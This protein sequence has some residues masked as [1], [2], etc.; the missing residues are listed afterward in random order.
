LEEGLYHYDAIDRL[1]EIKAASERGSDSTA[2]EDLGRYIKLGPLGTAL[3]PGDKPRVLLIDEIDKADIDLPNDLLHVF[4]E[5]EFEIRELVRIQSKMPQVK[6]MPARGRS[7]EDRIPIE[8]GWVRCSAFPLVVITSNSEREMPP[9]LRRRCLSLTIEPPKA[10]ELARIVEA[11][12]DGIDPSK[13]D[14]VI[15]DFLRRREER[16]TILAT[17][18]LLSAIHIVTGERAPEGHDLERVLDIVLHE[19]NQE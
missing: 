2:T 10:E 15:K 12:F 1:R 14:D 11:H 3:L 7:E 9:A 4:E 19:L 8:G 17:D 5:G 6:V 13:V 18:Q 16:G